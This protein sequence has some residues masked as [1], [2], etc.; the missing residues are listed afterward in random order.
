M[1]GWWVT[2]AVGESPE[3]SLVNHLAGEHGAQAQDLSLSES[4]IAALKPPF[5]LELAAT[6]RGEG[7]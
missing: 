6:S 5:Q 1:R 2:W 4:S 7:V 3:P